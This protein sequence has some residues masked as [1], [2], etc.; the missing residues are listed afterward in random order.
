M[1]EATTILSIINPILMM[2]ASICWFLLFWR[3][4]KHIDNREHLGR[5]LYDSLND[6]LSDLEVNVYSNKAFENSKNW[7]ACSIR[8]QK[9]KESNNDSTKH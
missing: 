9:E 5:L 7:M 3:V 4:R 2:F 1:N 8:V 6:R